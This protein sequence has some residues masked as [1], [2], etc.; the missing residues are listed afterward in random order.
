MFGG[1]DGGGGRGDTD[2]V[3]CGGGVMTD[4][5]VEWFESQY[6]FL[7]LFRRN[8]K[9]GG[10][11]GKFRGGVGQE[12]A[13][14]IHDAPEGHIKGIPFG[15]EGPRNS[16][17]DFS[18]GYPAPPSLLTMRKGSDI[19]RLMTEGCSVDDIDALG[20]EAIS[21]PFRE[22]EL[23]TNDVLFNSNSGGGGYGDP[24][25]ATPSSSPPT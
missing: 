2:G 3:D 1:I 4:H 8:I 11:P 7:Y 6:P 15:V 9:D 19:D 13:L 17:Q 18:A 22:F 24:L 16:G 12:L 21:L 25:I 23:T 5:N 20:G 14:A 10:G